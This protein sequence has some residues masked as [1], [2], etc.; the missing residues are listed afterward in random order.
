[1]A[2]NGHIDLRATGDLAKELQS[3]YGDLFIKNESNRLYSVEMKAERVNAHGNLFL[4]AWSNCDASRL[5][6]GWMM[7]CGADFLFYSFLSDNSLLVIPFRKLRQWAF[8]EDNIWKYGPPKKQ[9]AHSQMNDTRG[10]CVPIEVLDAA[11]PISHY[12]LDTGRLHDDIAF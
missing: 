5:K 2:P 4:E 3:T 6:P 7:T 1:M 9:T 10:W 8:V 11:L 12:D